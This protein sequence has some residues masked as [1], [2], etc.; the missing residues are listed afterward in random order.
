MSKV[1]MQLR[2]PC[3][4]CGNDHVVKGH[5][6]VAH[7]YNIGHGFQSDHCEGFNKPH[8]GHKDAVPFL[9]E[10]LAEL[11]DAHSI[12]VE[13]VEEHKQI[14]NDLVANS[15]HR[16]SIKEAKKHLVFHQNRVVALKWR[17]DWIQG[18]IDNW[19]EF[20]PELVDVIALEAEER[21][22][23][24]EE[25]KAK[26]AEKAKAEEEKQAR[27][28]ER[29]RKALE[30]VQLLL[31]NQW[32]LIY[33]D[34]V[35]VA[36]WQES[37]K[38]E[39][40]LL[41][42]VADKARECAVQLVIDG[43]LTVEDIERGYYQYKYITR[44]KRA[45]EKGGKQLDKLTHAPMVY[46]AYDLPELKEIAAQEKLEKSFFVTELEGDKQLDTYHVLNAPYQIMNTFVP[47]RRKSATSTI[48]IKD[49]DGVELGRKVGDA[50]WTGKSDWNGYE[51]FIR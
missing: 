1:K 37:Y 6:M 8:Y 34:D 5:R 33:I 49:F 26:K 38:S 36:E 10:Y 48:V 2:A 18:R 28:A 3:A 50:D 42:A 31:S 45:G 29:E 39:T 20:E 40:E 41:N 44:T 32:R 19:T 4:V 11:K 51:S 46:N 9:N 24:S 13:T 15:E 14:H 22:K 43:K 35:L 12:A 21:Q 47:E 7:G 17:I 25:A 16:L 30:K 27:I 23:R